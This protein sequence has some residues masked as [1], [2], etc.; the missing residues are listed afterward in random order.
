[1]TL[2]PLC[3][4]SRL[5]LQCIVV[6]E[7]LSVDKFSRKFVELWKYSVTC[8]HLFKCTALQ[9]AIKYGKGIYCWCAVGGQCEEI[10]ACFE[11]I[12]VSADSKGHWLQMKMLI[13]WLPGPHWPRDC[14][15]QLAQR[16]SMPGQITF[17]LLLWNESYHPYALRLPVQQY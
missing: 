14:P 10:P 15:P 2:T 6:V 11:E 5:L 7:C 9:R 3:Q 8:T 12:S 16:H 1:M 4:I 17:I 13:G